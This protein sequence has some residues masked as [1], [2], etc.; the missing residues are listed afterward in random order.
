MNDEILKEFEYF[1]SSISS[2]DLEDIVKKYDS[3][4]EKE[5]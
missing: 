2:E 4:F 3:E 5:N 1:L